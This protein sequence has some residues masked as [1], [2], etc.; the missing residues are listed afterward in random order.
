MRILEWGP[1]TIPNP[2]QLQ[3]G[4]TCS[5][6]F[7]VSPVERETPK[8]KGESG[9][10]GEN[11]GAKFKYNGSVEYRNVCAYINYVYLNQF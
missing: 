4:R 5:S 8:I 11:N 3:E 6:R 2:Q 10:M 1:F 9:E 7:G